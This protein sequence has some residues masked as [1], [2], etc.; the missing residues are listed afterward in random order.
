MNFFEAQDKARR[1]TLWL[2]L[3]FTL[4]VVGLIVLTNLFLLS[5][6]LYYRTDEIVFSPETL[7]YFYSWETFAT[8]AAGVVL[9]VL[10][11]SLYKMLSLAGGG[12]SIAEML[13]GQ[14]VSHATQDP[15]Q[16]RLLN[17]V[18]VSLI[19]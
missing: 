2:V 12:A 19:T 9:L 14:L 3:L 15:L 18:E 7:Y 17:V 4:A 1:N 16:R 5:M 10:G 8:V 13:G 11:G 6:Y